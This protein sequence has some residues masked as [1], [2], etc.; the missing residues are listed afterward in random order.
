MG[1][2][3]E[4]DRVGD[5]VATGGRKPRS[6]CDAQT[7]APTERAREMSR[8]RLEEDE[9]EIDPDFR[10][11][12]NMRDDGWWNFVAFHIDAPNAAELRER[13]RSWLVENI[14][15]PEELLEE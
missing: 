14:D 13:T 8:A 6:A 1:E 12:E 3:S 7:L 9:G 10:D 11:W 4:M 15:D 5:P 2:A